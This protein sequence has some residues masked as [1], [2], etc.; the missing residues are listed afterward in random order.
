MVFISQASYLIDQIIKRGRCALCILSVI[1]NFF[2]LYI[3]FFHFWRPF[4]ILQYL[5][6]LLKPERPIWDRFAVL[7]S[8]GIAWLYAQL[9]TSSGV[10][11][12]KPAKTEISC[13]TDR[14]ALFTAAPWWDFSNNLIKCEAFFF[15]FF[16]SK[17][18]NSLFLIW[19]SADDAT[20]MVVIW[21]RTLWCCLLL[22]IL[23]HIY[24]MPLFKALQG[25]N[26]PSYLGSP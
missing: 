2:F 14:T 17:P 12:N 11:N 16:I 10:Y 23:S 3:F 9:L 25:V 26:S 4:M 18:E 19:I 6:Q 7:F 20:H 13:R 24:S 15:F 8:V 1:C 22:L 5:P 21:D